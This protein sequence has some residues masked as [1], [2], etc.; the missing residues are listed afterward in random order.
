MIPLWRGQF[1]DPNLRRADKSAGLPDPGGCGAQ[2]R[3]PDQRFADPRSRAARRRL[4]RLSLGRD[5]RP[6]AARLDGP[7]IRL[8]RAH[9]RR[10]PAV[11]SARA[12]HRPPAAGGRVRAGVVAGARPARWAS[13]TSCCAA[14]CSTSASAPRSRFRP[15][16]SGPRLRPGGLAAPKNYGPPIAETPAIPFVDEI[17]LATRRAPRSRRRW[18]T[19]RSTIRCRSCARSGPAA[20]LL[21][22]GDSEGLVDASAAGHA[23]TTGTVRFAASQTTKQ[24]HAPPS[25]PTPTCC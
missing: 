18:R 14:T 7:S 5:A 24:R 13:V 3:P 21:V 12:G 19:S 11:G 20:P 17:S 1:V 10:H 6:A 16:S 15:G 8:P 22:A 25:R 9:P 23:H 2:C 4:L